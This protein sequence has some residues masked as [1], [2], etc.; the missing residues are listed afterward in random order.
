MFL[1]PFEKLGRFVELLMY[2]AY[3]VVAVCS[4]MLVTTV[5]FIVFIL[6][7]VYLKITVDSLW[8][9]VLM[10]GSLGMF[11]GLYYTFIKVFHNIHSKGKYEFYLAK[12]R[13]IKRD[14]KRRG[15]V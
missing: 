14:E 3:A 13:R 7:F 10:V 12:Q 8:W 6:I 2:M 11:I 4:A 1:F 9:I 15:V 5:F